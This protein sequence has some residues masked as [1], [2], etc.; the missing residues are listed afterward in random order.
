MLNDRKLRILA[1]V[2]DEYIMTGEPVSSKTISS[3][4]DIKVSPATVRNDMA[5]LE[6]LGYL[7]QPHTSAVRIPT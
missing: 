6:E 4:P 5:L 7:E 2:I 3:L 1:A